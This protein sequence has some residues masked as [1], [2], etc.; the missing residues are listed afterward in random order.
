MPSADRIMKILVLGASG[1]AGAAIMGAL[2][3][4]G[5]DLSGTSRAGLDRGKNPGLLQ[6]SLEEPRSVTPLL[7]E[8]RPDAVV[9]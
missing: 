6:F 8:I 4:A 7:E 9:S 2:Q 3:A 5:H 1:L